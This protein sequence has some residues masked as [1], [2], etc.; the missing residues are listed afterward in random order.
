GVLLERDRG[1]AAVHLT[2]DET[3]SLWLA[4][5]LSTSISNLPWSASARSA[6]AQGFASLPKARGQGVRPLLRRGVGRR[7]PTARAPGGLSAPRP[8]LLVAFESAFAQDACLAFDYTDRRGQGTKRVVEPHGLLLEAPAWYLLTRDAESGE[9]R[10]FRMDR[11]RR[12]RV[13]PER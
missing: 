4:S 6:L 11:I 3:A 12:P 1:V 10:M 9:A 5:R 13:L 2:A 7:P 8:E